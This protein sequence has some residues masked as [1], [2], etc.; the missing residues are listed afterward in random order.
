[1][2]WCYWYRM[3]QYRVIP[4]SSVATTEILSLNPNFGMPLITGGLNPDE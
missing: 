1:M 4:D 2:A 3:L